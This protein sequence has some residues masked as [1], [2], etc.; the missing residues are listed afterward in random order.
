MPRLTYLTLNKNK[1][2]RDVQVFRD[3]IYV[4]NIK[5]T[6]PNH[7]AYF[8]TGESYPNT[9]Y[10]SSIKDVKDALFKMVNNHIL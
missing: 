3:N 4:G 1:G 5:E 2:Q 6:S 7:F 10:Y 9:A 8:V